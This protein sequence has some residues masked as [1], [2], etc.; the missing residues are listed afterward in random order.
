MV[1]L[2]DVGDMVE[3]KRRSPRRCCGRCSIRNLR[4]L[5]STRG[6]CSALWATRLRQDV[7]GAGIGIRAALVHA[8]KGAELMDK[9][10]GASE[11]R[12]GTVPR[13]RDSAF[14]GV[15]RRDRALAARRGRASIPASPIGS[16]RAADGTRRHRPRVPTWWCRCDNRPD[17]IDPALLRRAGLEKLVF[18]E[19]PT[20]RR[21]AKSAHAGKSIRSKTTSTR[22]T[23]RRTGRLQRSRLRGTSAR[24]RTDRDVRARSTRRCQAADVAKAR[25][26]R[27]AVAGTRCRSS[28]AA[29]SA[30]R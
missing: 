14:A 5:E 3:T 16:G 11:R 22:R 25:E 7:R 15:P 4:A 21:V 1:T 24:S 28:A 26:K 23:G 30:A 8:V 13:A 20:P 27:S 18:V 29:F 10:V 12:C 2:D 6:R 17:L 9:W 19:H